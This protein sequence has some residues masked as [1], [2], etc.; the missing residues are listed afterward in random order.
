M[1]VWDAYQSLY[2]KCKSQRIQPPNN[3]PRR[4]VKYYIH[5]WA[6]RGFLTVYRD[7]GFL[8][9][10]NGAF[11]SRGRVLVANRYPGI[12]LVCLSAF[13]TG[14]ILA[15]RPLVLNKYLSGFISANDN[16][17]LHCSASN[18]ANVAKVERSTR[19]LNRRSQPWPA[20][21]CSGPGGECLWNITKSL[22]RRR[23]TLKGAC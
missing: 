5:R 19:P 12:C 20:N 4:V 14:R 22:M 23:Y 11:C 10:S 3:E 7:A 17:Y 2:A 9:S 1:S 8:N 18:M 13:G 15:D 6:C 16:D 21:N